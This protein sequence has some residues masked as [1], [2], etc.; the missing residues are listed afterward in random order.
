MIAE[1]DKVEFYFHAESYTRYYPVFQVDNWLSK[2]LPNFYGELNGEP[3]I[4]NYD[5]ILA[6]KNNQTPTEE[7]PGTL[8]FQY[9]GTVEGTVRFYLDPTNTWDGGGADNNCS[10]A[11]NWSSDTVPVSTEDIVL[12]ATSTK[13]LIWTLAAQTPLPLSLKMLDT[14]APQ[15]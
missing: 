2:A 4:E 7:Q 14:Q 1:E 5:Y 11:A 15:Q 12:S 13:D 8:I 10:T 6:F 3:L 9:L